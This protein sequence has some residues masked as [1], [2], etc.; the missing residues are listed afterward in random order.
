MLNTN[1]WLLDQK[2]DFLSDKKWQKTV[3]LIA[4][5]FKAPAGFVV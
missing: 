1:H 2:E 5:V 4:R 3:N